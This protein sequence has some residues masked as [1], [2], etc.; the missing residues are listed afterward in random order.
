MAQW[1]TAIL[2]EA[3]FKH[4]GPQRVC[5][6]FLFFFSSFALSLLLLLRESLFV[7][8]RAIG[9]F[10][11]FW[12]GEGGGRSQQIAAEK[13]LEAGMSVISA[14]SLNAGRRARCFCLRRAADLCDSARGRRRGLKSLAVPGIAVMSL[15]L[16]S[17]EEQSTGG[18]S[19]RLAARPA[20]LFF[21]FCVAIIGIYGCV[22]VEWII[23][24]HEC[25]WRRGVGVWSRSFCF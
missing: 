23:W 5:V 14:R 13:V 1:R 4:G 17:A 3:Y 16:V 25:V 12:V 7:Y 8:M 20:R 19:T 2:F 6:V 22:S 24:R 11:F 21:F 15:Q 10:W 18:Q 9:C